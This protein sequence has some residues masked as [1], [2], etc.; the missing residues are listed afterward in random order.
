MGC[1]DLHLRTGDGGGGNFHAF[2]GTGIGLVRYKVKRHIL[3][4]A[5]KRD[6]HH[7]LAAILTAHPNGNRI[8]TNRLYGGVVG[9]IAGHLI[10]KIRIIAAVNGDGA[11]FANTEFHGVHG[12]RNFHIGT[13]GGYQFNG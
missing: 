12:G 13:V 11:A 5:V 6:D 1:Q 8:F 2:L 9:Y 4:G 10:D 3:L 7:I